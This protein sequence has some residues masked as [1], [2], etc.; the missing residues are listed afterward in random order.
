M[1]LQATEQ[2]KE[3]GGSWSV[4]DDADIWRSFAAPASDAQF[5]QAWLALLCRQLPDVSAGVVLL[6][7]AEANTFQPVAVWP[8]V[9]RDLSFLSKVAERALMEGRGVVHRRDDAVRPDKA[10]ERRQR[11]EHRK[12]EKE[13]RRIHVAYPAE[14]ANRMV[15][16]VVLEGAARPEAEIHALLR[17][18]HWGVAWLH[19]LF[20]RRE[21]ASIE[22][23]GER[24]GSVMEVVATALR[25][26]KLQQ[27]L[28]D[29]ANHVTRQ[30]RC[31]RVSIGLVTDGT[32]RVTALSNAAW[33]EKNASI[34]KLYVAA[35]EDAF[36]KLAPVSYERPAATES[37]V[38]VVEDSAHAR[39]VRESGAQS[40]LS[41]PLSLGAE[42]VGILTLERDSGDGFSEAEQAWLDTL[43]SLLPA[44][45]DQKRSAER[46]YITRLRQDS[47]KLLE[48]LFGPRYLIWK[49]SASLLLATL[50]ILT[51]VEID[52][53]VSAKTVVEGE[54]QRSAVAPFESFVAAAYVRAGD[55]VKQGQ[56]LCLLDDRDLKL[57]QHKWHSERE[58][59]SRKLREAMANHELAQVQILSAQVQQAEAQLAL[60]TDRLSR[61]KIAAPFDGVIISG[62]L[63][64]LI[65][66]P[67]EPGKK[68]FEIAP[69]HGYRVILQV[70][71]REMRHL[72]IGQ[73]GKLMISGVIGDPIPLSVSRITPVATAQDGRNFFRVEAK[74][75]QVPAHLRPGME[76]IGK[77]SAGDRRLWWVLTHTF[78]D[79]LRLSMWTWLP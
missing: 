36:D 28:F 45:I 37:V 64:Q 14:V 35:M 30:L 39:L 20:H 53:R 68:L 76:G 43:A 23:K 55:T 7:S 70:D 4:E 62:D 41:V 13:R 48:R 44:A 49:F 27:I 33:F 57:E 29:V 8:D 63:S 11:R 42:C 54:V 17:Q 74:L 1:S 2:D 56:V 21:L 22:A 19:D 46:G 6:Q 24:I 67:V 72:K 38:A 9:A 34:M 59:H 12:G 60:V 32:V 75:E 31:S 16:A 5:C 26:G 25:R 79:W 58:Q 77:V 3:S 18:L 10:E 65:G 69:L 51:L 73:T 61:V 66:S 15:G 52:Y 78:T 47:K 40:I 71:E 50:M